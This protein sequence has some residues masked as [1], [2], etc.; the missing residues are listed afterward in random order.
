MENREAH[1]CCS[2]EWLIKFSIWYIVCHVRP[3][4][5]FM[6]ISTCIASRTKKTGM[7]LPTMSKLP[8]RVYI[9]TA[10][11]RG[12]GRV[13]GLPFSWMT[14]ENRTM[15][16]VCMHTWK[17]RFSTDFTSHFENLRA[18][19]WNCYWLLLPL[20][21]PT[22]RATSHWFLTSKC[23]DGRRAD[24]CLPCM[25]VALFCEPQTLMSHFS[26]GL[27]NITFSRWNRYRWLPLHLSFGQKSWWSEW[28]QSSII[29]NR[30][31]WVKSRSVSAMLVCM[32]L[33]TSSVL[34]CW[35]VP[36]HQRLA[37]SLHTWG[38]WCHGWPQ[39]NPWRLLHEHVRCAL[40]CAPCGNWR[41]SPPDDSPPAAQA[42]FTSNPDQMTPMPQ[43]SLSSLTSI[44]MDQ[45]LIKC[46][47]AQLPFLTGQPLYE[48]KW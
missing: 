27:L 12:S 42:L 13:S 38:E 20:H 2:C 3:G 15:R 8:S 14:V 39:S 41:S 47:T 5:V 35:W 24:Q 21:F 17:S 28:A 4:S 26:T 6:R 25:Y 40:E 32:L 34:K 23:G 7:L 44:P 33:I 45:M 16:G 11:P 9:L 10:N 30:G 36:E 22:A 31:W 19:R 43:S 29:S 18:S 46:S 48:G 37:G 1:E